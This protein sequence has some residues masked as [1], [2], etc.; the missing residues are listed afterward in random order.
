MSLKLFYTFSQLKNAH[1]CLKEIKYQA[2]F[3][4]NQHAEY[5]IICLFTFLYDTLG[6]DS[7][8]VLDAAVHTAVSVFWCSRSCKG[9]QTHR[10]GTSKVPL[11]DTAQLFPKTAVPTYFLQQCVCF[12]WVTTSSMYPG[13]SGLIFIHLDLWSWFGC[14]FLLT[15]EAYFDISLLFMFPL[16][17]NA[18]S[19]VLLILPLSC[20]FIVIDLWAL[21]KRPRSFLFPLFFL[22]SL[23]F[24][25]CLS[26]RS[27]QSTGN[28]F[29]IWIEK[30][31]QF[32]CFPKWI[33]TSLVLFIEKVLLKL[34]AKDEG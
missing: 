31:I 26:H 12:L 18:C 5:T 24:P 15:W 4:L 20:S 6:L 17:S 28:G 9:T 2:S 23:A 21:F 27:A 16:L 7:A 3:V 1:V 19:G 29:I 10:N 11:H 32:H 8:L 14:S 30:E 34:R 25:F 33:T 13:A 22:L